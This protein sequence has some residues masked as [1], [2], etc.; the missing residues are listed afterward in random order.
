M[1]RGAPL[2]YEMPAMAGDLSLSGPGRI[3][4]VGSRNIPQPRDVRATELDSLTVKTTNFCKLFVN[5]FESMRFTCI[6]R[7][8]T[9]SY[10]LQ[11]ICIRK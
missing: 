2:R 9:I 5:Y 10:E 4:L 8:P 7:C 11:D 1:T 3:R 6:N